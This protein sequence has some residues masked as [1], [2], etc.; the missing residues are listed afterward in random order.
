MIIVVLGASGGIGQ[1]LVRQGLEAGHVLRVVVREPSRLSSTDARLQVTRLDLRHPGVDRGSALIGV[2]EGADAVL[3]AL[4]ARTSADHGVLTEAAYASVAALRTAGV[5]R[6]VGVSAAPVGTVATP[7]RP[8]PPRDDPGDD[9]MTRRVLMPLVK[10]L[11]AAAYADAAAMEDVIR[12]SGLSWTLVRPPRLTE[13]PRTWRYRVSIDQNVRGGRRI[14]RAD[15]AAL[16]LHA[17]A[18][19]STSGHTLGVAD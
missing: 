16:M 15:V 4:G 2:V 9:L 7:Q 6:Y 8:H 18:D 3:S 1:E 5:D 12:S 17:I 11:F 19:P 10:H 13:G 14:S